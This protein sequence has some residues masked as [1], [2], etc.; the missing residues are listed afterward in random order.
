MMDEGTRPISHM[1][2]TCDMKLSTIFFSLNSLDLS[3]AKSTHSLGTC[4]SASILK[5]ERRKGQNKESE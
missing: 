1:Y 4:L 5:N 2:I 3:R